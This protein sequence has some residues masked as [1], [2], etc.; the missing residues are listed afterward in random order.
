MLPY[1]EWNM[2]LRFVFQHDNDPKHASLLVRE[3]LQENLIR[4]M[5]WPSQSPDL[6]PI[7]HLWEEVE[8]RI[9]C[10]NFRNKNE[11]REK[12][13]EVWNEMPQSM[14]DKLIDSMPRRCAAVIKSKGG[15]TKY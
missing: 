7:E 14:L 8:R 13:E 12:I 5:K 2:P 6:N 10:Q 4:V 1:A 15:P 3:W 11:L 9:R